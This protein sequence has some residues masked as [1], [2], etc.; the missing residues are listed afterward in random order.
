MND[1]GLLSHHP[2]R[3]ITTH[4]MELFLD[5]IQIQT[6]LRIFSYDIAALEHFREFPRMISLLWSTIEKVYGYFQNLVWEH[7]VVLYVKVND[8]TLMNVQK[9]DFRQEQILDKQ[10]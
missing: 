3:G 10:I 8:H 2:D 1:E 6:L 4:Y 7:R 5:N 9:L